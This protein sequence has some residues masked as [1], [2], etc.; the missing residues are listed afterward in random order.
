MNKF[1]KSVDFPAQ[2]RGSVSA[3]LAV[4]FDFSS[5]SDPKILI[6]GNFLGERIVLHFNEC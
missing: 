4:I 6:P 1:L 3:S 5:G 2:Y